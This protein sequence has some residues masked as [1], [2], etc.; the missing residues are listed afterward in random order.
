MNIEWKPAIEATI[1]ALWT[2]GFLFTAIRTR[3]FLREAVAVKAIVVI[4]DTDD[5][6]PVLKFTIAGETRRIKAR[7]GS[8]RCRGYLGR[9]VDA[10]YSASGNRASLADWDAVWGPVILMGLLGVILGLVLLPLLVLALG[11]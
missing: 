3:R 8:I 10:L 7:F 9:E 4:V 1:L 2:V 6:C 5:G 11:W